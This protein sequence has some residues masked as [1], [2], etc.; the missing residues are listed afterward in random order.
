MK[1]KRIRI[2][3]LLLAGLLL[4]GCAADED[5]GVNNGIAEEN[6]GSVFYEGIWSIDDTPIEQDYM[7]AW[8]Y[9]DSNPA[10]VLP[11]F[12]YQAVLDN[13]LPEFQG[14]RVKEPATPSVIQLGY[15]GYTSANSYYDASSNN[16]VD[17]SPYEGF[18][19]FDIITDDE[20]PLSA[21]LHLISNQSVFSFNNTSANCVLTIDKAYIYKDGDKPRVVVLNPERKLTFVSTKRL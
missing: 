12:P 1:M 17:G 9:K 3:G 6:G 21:E 13:L 16:N 2:I 7:I 4:T 15:V 19:L 10:I 18:L 8:T 14:S 5:L 11:N 20:T